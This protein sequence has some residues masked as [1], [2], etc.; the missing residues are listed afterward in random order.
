MEYEITLKNK[1]VPELS[2]EFADA[3]RLWLES[4]PKAAEAPEV[5]LRS[6]GRSPGI[7]TNREKSTARDIQICQKEAKTILRPSI[8]KQSL[9]FCSTL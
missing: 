1:K 5:D 2:K 9:F 7:L 6:D 8:T 4:I 3:V